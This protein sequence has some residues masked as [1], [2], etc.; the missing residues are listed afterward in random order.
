LQLLSAPLLKKVEIGE[1][2]LSKV[3]VDELLKLVR[4]RRIMHKVVSIS[5]CNTSYYRDDLQPW[6]A[7]EAHLN[8]LINSIQVAFPQIEITRAAACL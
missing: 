3:E 5:W 6:M 1:C 2:Y 4:Q 8:L 7:D